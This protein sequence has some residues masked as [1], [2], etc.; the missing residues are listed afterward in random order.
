MTHLVKIEHAVQRGRIALLNEQQI[1]EEC[2]NVREARQLGVARGGSQPT[3]ITVRRAQPAELVQVGHGG[4]GL[5]RALQPVHGLARKPGHYLHHDM[6]SV[7]L[8]A[9]GGHA[10]HKI[11]H[12]RARVAVAVLQHAPCHP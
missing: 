7:A 2:A 1:T 11:H 3:K 6:E 5:P 10:N 12:C 4:D 9:L 8:A